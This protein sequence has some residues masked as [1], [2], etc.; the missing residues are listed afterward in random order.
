MLK[1]IS[2]LKL[3]FVLITSS[4]F[5]FFSCDENEPPNPDLITIKNIQYNPLPTRMWFIASD[6]NGNVLDKLLIN[7]E[8]LT[9]I[10]SEVKLSNPDY[11]KNTFHLTIL[12][13][14]E[15]L[16]DDQDGEHLTIGFL[17]KG[18]VLDMNLRD[19][20]NFNSQFKSS[21]I[22]KS[23][24][25]INNIGLS[26]KG[27]ERVIMQNSSNINYS[28]N[29]KVLLTKFNNTNGSTIPI[30]YHLN[31]EVFNGI[32]TI[33]I[34][35]DGLSFSNFSNSQVSAPAG[36]SGEYTLYGFENYID[37]L[38]YPVYTSQKEIN[39]T[40]INLFT[41]GNIFQNYGISF[42]AENDNEALFVYDGTQPFDLSRPSYTLLDYK[43]ENKRLTYS[44]RSQAKNVYFEL[45]YFNAD[46]IPAHFGSWTIQFIGDLNRSRTIQLPNLDDEIINDIGL[47]Y[48]EILSQPIN[49]VY[50]F[51]NTNLN[52][53]LSLHGPILNGSS[54]IQNVGNGTYKYL[55]I[56]LNN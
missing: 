18:T 26:M 32:E 48:S 24:N 21:L 46:D 39:S 25:D 2:K 50:M 40:S 4:F 52:N 13:V 28:E 29:S 37:V 55:R 19:Y 42:Y 7:S 34:D 6:E 16:L 45:T 31:S 8:D 11:T 41:P 20:E 9:E 14:S 3:S 17:E 15:G 10:V 5:I 1:I 23:G 27:L 44:G 51:E 56:G 36:L 53:L 49:L 38:G 47:N 54:Y 22:N 12:K 35:V 43:F 33:N 30:S